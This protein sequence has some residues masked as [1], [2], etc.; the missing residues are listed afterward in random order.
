M[1]NILGELLVFSDDE[2]TKLRDLD[3]Q[4]QHKSSI[5]DELFYLS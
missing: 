3:F 5:F 4:L 1:L 2:R